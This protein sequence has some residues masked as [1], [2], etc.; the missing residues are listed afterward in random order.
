MQDKIVILIEETPREATF[1]EVSNLLGLKGI[2]PLDFIEPEGHLLSNLY[3]DVFTVPL[4]NE[5]IGYLVH[6]QDNLLVMDVINAVY[7]DTERLTLVNT[8]LLTEEDVRFL[9]DSLISTI[10]YTLE[11]SAEDDAWAIYDLSKDYRD[12]VGI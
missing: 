9:K 6:N 7:S 4:A 2:D 10:Q 5:L 1:K 3:R 11:A 8:T 12:K